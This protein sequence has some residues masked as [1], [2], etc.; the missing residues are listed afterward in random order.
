MN[1]Q[2]GVEGIPVLLTVVRFDDWVGCAVDEVAEVH[3][4]EE[5]QVARV[6]QGVTSEVENEYSDVKDDDA[7]EAWKDTE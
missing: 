1:S 3:E 2:L 4:D 5:I 6:E 7:K